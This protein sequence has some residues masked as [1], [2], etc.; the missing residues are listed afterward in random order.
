MSVS[1]LHTHYAVR[2]YTD[3][4]GAAV[5][6]G[7]ITQQA[8]NTG[9]EVVG[10]PTSGEVY[11][12]FMSVV[13]QKPSAAFTT[14]SIATALDNCGFSGLGIASATNPGLELFAYKHLAG[15]TR[16]GD[17][18]HRKYTI[19]KG[20]LVPQRLSV[21]HRGDATISYLA[22]SVYDGSNDPLVLADTY[23]LPTGL[24]DA[25]RFTLGPVSIGGVTLAQITGLEIDFGIRAETVGA[26]SDIWDTLVSIH[27]TTPKIMLKG[28]DVEWLKSAN[29]PLIGK[30][31]THANTIL[32]LRKRA[33]ASTYVADGTAQ[34]I[35]MTAAGLAFIEQPM[36]ASNGTSQTSLVAPLYYDGTN[37][38][39]VI[40]TTAAIV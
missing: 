23:T 18:L 29:I 35:S 4:M 39:M 37:D 12:R 28:I 7:G 24:T 14:K 22:L 20:I 27:Q 25:E 6:L 13:G 32:Y 9:T 3:A 10:S 1:R 33:A 2:L 5:L 34:H 26:D 15:S 21:D 38:I 11:P 8:I 19:R 17:S 16:S 40:D 36:E 30:A 31:A